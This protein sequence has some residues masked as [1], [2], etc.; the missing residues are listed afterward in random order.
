MRIFLNDLHV[1]AL[2]VYARFHSFQLD[3]AVAAH[4]LGYGYDYEKT[5]A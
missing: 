5:D 1:I 3:P 2:N 4:S